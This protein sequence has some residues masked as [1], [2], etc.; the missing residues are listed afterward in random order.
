MA[1]RDAGLRNR[2]FQ[3]VGCLAISASSV[4]AQSLPSSDWSGFFIGDRNASLS[5]KDRS[6]AISARGL[7]DR[8]SASGWHTGYQ[9]DFGQFVLGGEIEY[10]TSPGTTGSR[11]LLS[12]AQEEDSRHVKARFG[13]DAGSW[14][15]YA[16]VGYGWQDLSAPTRRLDDEGASFGIG[17]AFQVNQWIVLGTELLDR[18]LETHK[19]YGLSDQLTTTL[20]ISF[21]F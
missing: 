15:P 17:A 18:D 9:H 6:A 1:R 3:A 11:G 10:D 19:G 8:K 14:L 16:I 20:R 5:G 13:Y 4:S 21:D 12:G 7:H 2:M